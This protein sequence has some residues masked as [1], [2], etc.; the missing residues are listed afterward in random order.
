MVADGLPPVRTATTAPFDVL[1]TGAGLAA[2][3]PESA[4]HGAQTPQDHRQLSRGE[5]PPS[6]RNQ[7]NSGPFSRKRRKSRRPGAVLR[8]LFSPSRPCGH[9][10]TKLTPWA[11][12]GSTAPAFPPAPGPASTASVHLLSASSGSGRPRKMYLGE[13]DPPVA[14][15][16]EYTLEGNPGQRRRRGEFIKPLATSSAAAPF[17]APAGSAPSCSRALGSAQYRRLRSPVPAS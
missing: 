8:P 13:M 9:P 3:G 11:S 4:F 15:E 14:T 6:P 5:I 17:C 2:V 10:T 12:L 16:N 1:A 7:A